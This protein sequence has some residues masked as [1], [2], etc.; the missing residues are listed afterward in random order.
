MAYLTLASF[1]KLCNMIITQCNEP[2]FVGNGTFCGKD[3]DGDKFP[4]GQ[5]NCTQDSLYC[6]QVMA[7]CIHINYCTVQFMS[8]FCYLLDILTYTT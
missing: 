3:T 1:V 8:V 7:T 6:Q 2:I 5:L 4:D